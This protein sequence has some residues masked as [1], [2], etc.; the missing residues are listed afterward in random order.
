MILELITLLI[1]KHFVADFL[2]Q[3]NWMVNQKGYYLQAGGVVHA[4]IHGILT[5]FVLSYV[6]GEGIAFVAALLDFVLHYHIDWAKMK[7]G[8]TFNWTTNDRM[9]WVAIG[10]DQM[11][12][13]L[14]YVLIILIVI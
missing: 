10:F 2:L 1:I 4:L 5:F 11:L 14:T 8:R 9:F 12:H 6:T 7:L 3:N 13:Y